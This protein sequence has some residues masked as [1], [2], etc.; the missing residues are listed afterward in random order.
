MTD[1]TLDRGAPAGS[2]RRFP[3]VR[4]ALAVV[5][6]LA[7]LATLVSL[8]NWQ[9]RRL[10]WKEGL[11]AKIA[12]RMHAP[13]VPLSRV[14]K[15]YRDGKDIEYRHVEVG[16]TFD[17]SKERHFLATFEGASGFFV[18]APLT[19]DDGEVLFV[20]RGFVPY[21]RK[22]S[23]TRPGSLAHGH[24][25]ITGLARAAPPEKPGS[26]VPD[27]DI[28]KNIF[29]WKDLKAMASSTG[30]SGARLVPFFVDADRTPGSRQLPVGGVTV[31]DLP[32]DH[33]QYAVTW[34]GLAVVLLFVSG[35]AVYRR[36]TGGGDGKDVPED[37]P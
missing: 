5:L 18:Y 13:V 6:V 24:V 22:A 7:A 28:A 1:D 23:A 21:D 10:H 31:V 4:T 14:E 29:Y 19:T 33:L 15:L 37:H 34:Y 26:M 17:N 36:W 12:A 35:T 3:P 9:V 20:N 32:N 16:G 2:A 8:G 27:N 25:T 30:L 11:L